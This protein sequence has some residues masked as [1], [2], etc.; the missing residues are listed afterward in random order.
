MTQLPVARER[1]AARVQLPLTATQLAGWDAIVDARSPS[2]F[3][4]DHLPGAVNCP[5]LDDDERE[6]VGTAYKQRGS[7][8][9][10]RLG[11]PL[12]AANI[13]R[14]IATQFADRPKGQLRREHLSRGNRQAARLGRLRPQAPNQCNHRNCT[15]KQAEHPANTGPIHGNI[16][17][18]N[19]TQLCS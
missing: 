12:V 9:A 7:F 10:K 16:I 1:P 17:S 8:E 13:A 18:A 14:I 5:V 19:R 2:E 6:L 3:A 11:A 4:E 15:Q